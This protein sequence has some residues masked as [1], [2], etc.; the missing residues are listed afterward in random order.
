MTTLYW[1]FEYLYTIK[2]VY[3]LGFSRQGWVSIFHFHFKERKRVIV[4]FCSSVFLVCSFKMNGMQTQN[5]QIN[6]YSVSNN[7]L[8]MFGKNGINLKMHG[9]WKFYNATELSHKYTWNG[10]RLRKW[11]KCDEEMEFTGNILENVCFWVS[12]FLLKNFYCKGYKTKR[13]FNS[14]LK[15]V[16]CE[17][18]TIFQWKSVILT[19]LPWQWSNHNLIMFTYFCTFLL[20]FAGQFH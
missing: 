16:R 2:V 13:Q 4:S 3:L 20:S 7:R 10:S 15:T 12:F 14:D 6:L 1:A 19:Y 18:P 17:L 11:A 9:K 8:K 5:L